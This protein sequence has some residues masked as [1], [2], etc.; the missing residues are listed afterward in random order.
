MSILPPSG[1]AISGIEAVKIVRTRS[2]RSTSA[3]MDRSQLLSTSCKSRRRVQARKTGSTCAWLSWRSERR[4]GLHITQ[5]PVT[6][7]TAV[8]VGARV[9]TVPWSD[10]ASR[11]ATSLTRRNHRVR[12]RHRPRRLRQ[13]RVAGS[14]WKDNSVVRDTMDT[15]SG[16]QKRTGIGMHTAL[17][18]PQCSKCSATRCGTKTRHCHSEE[19]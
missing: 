8:I 15:S 18:I 2:T 13:A 5:V 14:K 9:F 12:F 6:P 17:P 1:C 11:H 19:Q 10:I 4:S 3:T 16:H 7:N